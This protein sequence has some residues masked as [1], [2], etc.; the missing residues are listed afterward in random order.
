MQ[1][2]Q[3]SCHNELFYRVMTHAC[4]KGLP[5]PEKG[6][7]MFQASYIYLND[8]CHHGWTQNV[9]EHEHETTGKCQN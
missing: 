9:A 3:V 2:K 4:S 1:G 6:E 5:V 8:A 7:K